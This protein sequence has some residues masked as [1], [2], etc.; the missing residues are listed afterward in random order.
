[1]TDDQ[2]VAVDLVEEDWKQERA[3]NKDVEHNKETNGNH[4]NEPESLQ[5]QITRL[6]D[7]LMHSKSELEK[8]ETL[9]LQL[10]E[11]LTIFAVSINI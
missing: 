8:Q 1:M 7:E 4:K 9:N 5:A 3:N 11:K 6:R 10:T 2:R